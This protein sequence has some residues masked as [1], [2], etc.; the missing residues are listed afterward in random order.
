MRNVLS[1]T[2]RLG[3]VSLSKMD[4]VF[5]VLSTERY[6]N[7]KMPSNQRVFQLDMLFSKLVILWCLSHVFSV[8]KAT[9]K[10]SLEMLY[11]SEYF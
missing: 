2:V 10:V 5:L 1:I 3:H 11:F 4:Y 7:E 8:V 9:V 6:V